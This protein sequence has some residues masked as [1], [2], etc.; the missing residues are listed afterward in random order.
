MPFKVNL[1][2]KSTFGPGW[3]ESYY[4]NSGD[5]AAAKQKTNALITARTKIMQSPRGINGYDL[6]AYRVSDVDNAKDGELVTSLGNLVS[7][8]K[9]PAGSTNP[10]LELAEDPFTALNIRLQAGSDH[11][12]N[13]K[14]KGFP[15]GA[16]NATVATMDQD[17]LSAVGSF[18]DF[19]VRNDW[20]MQALDVDPVTNPKLRFQLVTFTEDF[21]TFTTD[22]HGMAKNDRFKI[23]SDDKCDRLNGKSFVVHNVPNNQSIE[24]L[25][26][27]RKTF[28]D[29][30]S[31]G[32]FR[33]VVYLY[34]TF[35]K[36]TIV[37]V[38]Q[39][40]VGRPF[41]LPVGRRPNRCK[42]V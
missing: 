11:F 1:L 9:P 30:S 23:Y 42:A 3:S 29:A 31:P 17:F 27:W 15:D 36:G 34:P 20:A 10:G 32:F 39:A 4:A 6:H 8:W 24:V 12:R 25:N 7:Y 38:G 22:V 14:L 28:E 21:I 13:M 37:R 19:L 35:T 26:P 16:I 33:Q 2:I 41:G 18:L 40:K 5:I